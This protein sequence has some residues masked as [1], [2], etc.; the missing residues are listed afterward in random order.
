MSDYPYCQADYTPH[1]DAIAETYGQTLH[2]R[3]ELVAKLKV[4]PTSGRNLRIQIQR[5]NRSLA[6]LEAAARN[7]PFD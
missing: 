1:L 7:H 4:C 5:L 2:E 3:D 6:R